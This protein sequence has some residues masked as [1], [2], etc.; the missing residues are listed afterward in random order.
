MVTDDRDD[1][2]LRPRTPGRTRT[3]KLAFWRRDPYGPR[4]AAGSSANTPGRTRTC[5]P[6]FRR[7]RRG[8]FATPEET[9]KLVVSALCQRTCESQSGF[10]PVVSFTAQGSEKGTDLRNPQIHIARSNSSVPLL[11]QATGNPSGGHP[12]RPGPRFFSGNC[13]KPEPPSIL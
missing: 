12:R 8:D 1:A 4:S 2:S 13:F 6:R 9:T 10:A 11:S 5:N 3:C 7:L